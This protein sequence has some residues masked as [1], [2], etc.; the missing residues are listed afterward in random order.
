VVEPGVQTML[1]SLATMPEKG[2]FTKV[3]SRRAA[4]LFSRIHENS[5]GVPNVSS[6][7]YFKWSIQAICLVQSL[8]SLACPYLPISPS[9]HEIRPPSR[10]KLHFYGLPQEFLVD[11]PNA[12]RKTL[13]FARNRPTHSSNLCSFRCP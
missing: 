7:K 6:E 4:T 3:L 2:V 9:H 13:P 1:R 10:V 5:C 8:V 12:Q 11:L